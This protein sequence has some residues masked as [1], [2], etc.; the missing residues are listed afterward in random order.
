MKSW[1]KNELESF[2]LAGELRRR[3]AGAFLYSSELKS[4][5]I[6]IA[7]SSAW[8]RKRYPEFKRDVGGTAVLCGRAMR[9]SDLV[10]SSAGTSHR[11]R[12]SLLGIL[13]FALGAR[14]LVAFDLVPGPLFGPF[15]T[16]SAPETMP[17]LEEGFLSLLAPLTKRVSNWYRDK[18]SFETV[19]TCHIAD[20]ASFEG[21]LLAGEVLMLGG[22]TCLW[23]HSS[24]VIH[25]PI[26][27][28]KNVAQITVAARSTGKHWIKRFGQ[29]KVKVDPQAILSEMPPAPVHDD[30]NPLTVVLFAGAHMLSR[31]P[32]VNYRVHKKSWEQALNAFTHSD[33]DLKLKHKSIWETREWISQ[34]A[35][36][37]ADLSFTNVHAKKLM[38]PNMVFMSISAT[39]TAIFEGIARGIPG[40]TVQDVPV[41]ETP[42]YDPKVI[43][44]IRSDELNRFLFDLNSKTAWEELRDRQMAWFETETSHFDTR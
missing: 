22:K 6:R 13:R 27:E 43:P 17:S 39:S 41:D 1:G 18:L 30:K 15:C 26:H 29:E 12:P 11:Q 32:L 8:L 37:G 14:P 40:F 19:E 35:P 31:V 38:L 34:R 20:H 36:E 44:R 24:N 10:V 25:M 9:R 16:Y 3:N 28:P 5:N 23:P 33:V 21:G 42:Y 4:P 7:L 2:Y